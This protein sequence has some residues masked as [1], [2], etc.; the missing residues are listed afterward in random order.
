M[1]IELK[2][3]EEEIDAFINQMIEDTARNMKQLNELCD[4]FSEDPDKV[5]KEQ[6]RKDVVKKKRRGRRKKKRGAHHKN[7]ALEA[8][9]ARTDNEE[10]GKKASG[11]CIESKALNKEENKDSIEPT[12]LTDEDIEVRISLNH[13]HCLK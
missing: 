1:E 3:D 13:V 9:D 2:I 7:D 6:Q 10:K 12:L 4:K 8:L 11:D 5:S